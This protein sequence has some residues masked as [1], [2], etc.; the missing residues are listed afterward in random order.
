MKRFRIP[1]AVL[2]ASWA[3][4]VAAADLDELPIGVLSGKNVVERTV[5]IDDQTTYRVTETTK[6]RALDGSPIT[7]EQLRAASRNHL[8]MV[9]Y[10]DQGGALT[11]LQEVDPPR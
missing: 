2:A 4:P 7:L 1:L 8:G 3:F 11:L 5:T 9:A 6:L 10:E